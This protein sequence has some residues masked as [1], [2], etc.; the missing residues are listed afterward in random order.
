MN[1]LALERYTVRAYYFRLAPV[2]WAIW[3]VDDR[4][5]TLAL[6]SDWGSYAHRWGRGDWLGVDP[7]DL[8][9]AIA[10]RL[11]TDYLARKLFGD[12]ARAYD[13]EKTKAAVRGRVLDLRRV[14]ELDREEARAVWI[15]LD[16]VDWYCWE[17]ASRHLQELLAG[18]VLGEVFEYYRDSDTAWFLVVRDQLFPL[19]I[20]ALRADRKAA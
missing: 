15:Q 11:G 1:V 10:T 3:Y 16:K 8:T 14:C 13:A 4:T 2:G 20:D 18:V 9:L 5:G 17:N 6:E 19:L 7:P 12:R